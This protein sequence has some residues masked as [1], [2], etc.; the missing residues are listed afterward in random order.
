MK[1]KRR[2]ST[3]M[4]RRKVKAEEKER[5]REREREFSIHFFSLQLQH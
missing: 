2:G 1:Q 4:I 3:R 5:E